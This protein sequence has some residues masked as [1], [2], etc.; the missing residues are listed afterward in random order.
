MLSYQNP[1]KNLCGYGL[2]QSLD[3]LGLK[4]HIVYLI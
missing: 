4:T 1:R 2:V 3:Y